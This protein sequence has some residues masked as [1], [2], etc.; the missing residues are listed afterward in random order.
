[1][2]ATRKP[3]SLGVLEMVKTS[4]KKTMISHLCSIVRKTIWMFP[5]KH[6][7]LSSIWRR[8]YLKTGKAVAHYPLGTGLLKWQATVQS[9]V[10]ACAGF[11]VCCVRKTTTVPPVIHRTKK[12]GDPCLKRHLS[13][14]ENMG[15]SGL[16]CEFL[17]FLWAWLFSLQTRQ[18][19]YQL[20][21]ITIT[22]DVT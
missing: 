14:A 9:F 22:D 1:M 19:H 7:T 12:L 17:S 16:K 2:E 18:H 8:L 3:H 21:N 6:Q 15:S 4:E 5:C 10:C 11:T 20:G 13:I